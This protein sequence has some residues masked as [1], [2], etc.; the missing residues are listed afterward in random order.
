LTNLQTNFFYATIIVEFDG[1]EYNYNNASGS[2]N[3]EI[4]R[5][6]TEQSKIKV[7]I[8]PNGEI[9]F[10]VSSDCPKGEQMKLV[11]MV[12]TEPGMDLTMLFNK[13]RWG[14]SHLFDVP[15]VV[16]DESYGVRGVGKFPLN[17][18]QM[19]MTK[20]EI[21]GCGH[22]LLYAIGDFSQGDVLEN[23]IE[24]SGTFTFLTSDPNATLYMIWD[25]TDKKVTPLFGDFDSV[26]QGETPNLPTTSLNGITGVWTEITGFKY[27]NTLKY[28]FTPD[29]GQC[30]EKVEVEIEE[31]EKVTPNFAEEVYICQ[32]EEVLLPVQSNNGISG[33][34]SPEPNNQ[35][36]TTYTF[37]P[38]AGQCAE[39]VEMTVVVMEK[40]EPLFNLQ[41]D[42]CQGESISF[43]NISS[44]GISGVWSYKTIE[45]SPDK[46]IRRYS[47]KPDA[48]QCAEIFVIDIAIWKK[49]TL[50]FIGLQTDF[51]QG[52]SIVLPNISSNGISGVWSSELIEE[53]EQYYVYN[54]TFTPTLCAYPF[55]ADVT[56]W[57]KKTPE[58]GSLPNMVCFDFD[59]PQAFLDS[60]P[61]I[62]DNGITG[63]WLF[64]DGIGSAVKMFFVPDNGQCID[65]ENFDVH[66]F[67]AGYL[68]MFYN[69][70]KE[71][72]EGESISFPNVSDN[73]ISGVWSSELIEETNDYF[74][75][76]Y[77]FK[78]SSNCAFH[79]NVTVYKKQTPLFNNLQVNYCAGA[80]DPNL[81]TTS[82]NGIIGVWTREVVYAGGS[83]T[84]W[85]YT[86]TP[87][88]GQ[89]VVSGSVF[90]HELT[91][92]KVP[93]AEDFDIVSNSEFTEIHVLANNPVI[94]EYTHIEIIEPPQHGT[95]QIITSTQN[96]KDFILYSGYLGHRRTDRFTY[97]ICNGNISYGCCSNI[98][99]VNIS[100]L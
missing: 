84:R 20:A 77:T 40:V 75:Y 66:V 64:G 56:I 97:R 85:K 23:A 55:V 95:I 86:F 39:E 90:I 3:I 79:I 71:Y 5:T 12:L 91:I 78:T 35:E 21:K 8:I 15:N 2:Q 14:N 92:W 44:N 13:F 38:D 74:L 65:Y 25:Y 53:T 18:S 98:A 82:L 94:G 19:Y 45:N 60:L 31:I 33:S 4:D 80:G 6:N 63:Y 11:T 73:G 47:F 7:T 68:P 1:Q 81:P 37:T 100:F 10:D 52:E 59:N 16:Y 24:H 62:S 29:A 57:K 17:N 51:C 48:G 42:F 50:E 88:A 41:K 76:L 46:W 9:S 30:A 49:K 26:C 58:F 69:L 87:D 89:C 93:V 36:T 32:G 54:Y 27:T 61:K 70:K 99:I 43:P 72:C 28:L 34:W 22:R 96:Y 83:F 67:T